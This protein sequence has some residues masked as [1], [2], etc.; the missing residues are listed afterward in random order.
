MENFE[1]AF[2]AIER[3]Q[4]VSD[5]T[6][7]SISPQ[8]AI[9]DVFMPDY[10]YFTDMQSTIGCC[11]AGAGKAL[12]EVFTNIEGNPTHLSMEYL[13]KKIKTLDEVPLGNGTT[14]LGI[15]K[16][17]NKLGV[18]KND[19]LPT[20]A[21]GVDPT[22]FAK[23]DTTDAMNTDAATH[24]IDIGYAFQWSPT[25]QDIKTAIYNHKGVILLMRVGKEFWTDKNGVSSWQEKD[26]LPLQTIYPQ[27]SGHFVLAYAYDTKYI[28]WYNQWSGQ[29]GRSGIGYFGAD[30]A[31]RVVELGTA[32][33]F[34][35]IKISFSSVLKVGSRGS[36]VSVLQKK[37]GI[38]VDGI[39]GPKTKL[40]VEKFQSAHGLV[41]DGIVGHMTNEALNNN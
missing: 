5:I 11:G 26:I 18:C 36:D 14:M 8:T 20:N 29:W 6:L 22:A 30:Y 38:P 17:L 9:P 12:T 4:T 32:V 15:M 27:E 28:Y 3:E 13:W 19:L 23:D 41:A 37:L 33:D 40:A 24:K 7:G 2:G 25:L 16:A 39:F 1:L 10:K 34:N 35:K 21:V 31:S